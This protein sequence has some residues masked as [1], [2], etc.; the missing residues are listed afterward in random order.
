[1]D[2]PWN[3]GHF[4]DIYDFIFYL[5]APE[6]RE[7]IYIYIYIRNLSLIALEGLKD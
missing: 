5:S 3:H 7:N 2:F 4:N 6:F 1:M